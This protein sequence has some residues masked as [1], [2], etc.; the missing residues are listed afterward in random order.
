[1]PRSEGYVVIKLVK[2]GESVGGRENKVKGIE[3][4]EETA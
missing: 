2:G 4:E 3:D 1:M